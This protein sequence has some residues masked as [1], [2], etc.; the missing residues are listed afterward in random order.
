MHVR[1][2]I[3]AALI[4]ALALCFG[5]SAGWAQTSP[6]RA[7]VVDTCGGVTLPLN[8]PALIYQDKNGR[9]C[10]SAF[11]S[12]AGSQE[13]DIAESRTLN[14][15][16][17][18]SQT[19]YTLN[20]QSTFS[21]A[22]TGLTASGATVSFFQSNDWN[23]TAGTFTPVSEVNTGNGTASLTRNTD[24]QS[25]IGVEGAKAVRVQVT[26]AGTGTVT[27]ASNISVRSRYAA[28]RSPVPGLATT[29]TAISPTPLVARATPALIAKGAAANLYGFSFTQGATAGFLAIL[30]ATVIPAA[31]A[32][33]TPVECIPVAANT[34]LRARHDIPDRYATGIVALSTSSCTTYTAVTPILMSVMAQ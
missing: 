13:Q 16:S 6:T 5:A 9:T 1:T 26:T 31:S 19:T 20:G 7:I 12:V 32:A 29:A 25:A 4:G 24:G 14:A 21:F 30:D 22:F 10:T 33:I 18:A 3:R 17:T 34:G 8:D 2:Y 11:S 28:I 15:A 27:L 23:G